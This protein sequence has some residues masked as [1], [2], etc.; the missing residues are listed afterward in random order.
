[1]LAQIPYYISVL[2]GLITLVV[3][4]LFAKAIKQGTA[5]HTKKTITLF[6]VFSLF[7]LSL[8]A[9]LSWNSVYSSN[10]TFLP[11]KI[12]LFGIFPMVIVLV[13]LWNTKWGKN[14]SDGLSSKN[15]VY[16]SIVRIPVELVLYNLF[17]RKAIPKIM[18][19]EGANFD[20]VAGISALLITMHSLKKTTLNMKIVTYWNSISLLLLLNI[21]CIAFFSTPTPLQKFGFE[22]PNIAI[23]YFPFCW[24]PTFI[25]PVILFSHLALWRHCKQKSTF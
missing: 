10:N 19:F 21:V 12:V 23:L 4:L 9:M 14:F 17:L 5:T 22:Q 24:L 15:L 6:S 18:T 25:V 7:W 11:P 2:F 13:I 16:L 1:M 8:Q 20:I 3:F